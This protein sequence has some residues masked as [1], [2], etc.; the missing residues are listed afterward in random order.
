[1]YKPAQID[2]SPLG[3]IGKKLGQVRQD[4]NALPWARSDW[5]GAPQGYAMGW[6]RQPQSFPG[7]YSPWNPQAN[8]PSAYGIGGGGHDYGLMWRMFAG[9]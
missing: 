4:R 1:M 8:R 3:D 2:F 6:H 9:R 7:G 5:Q